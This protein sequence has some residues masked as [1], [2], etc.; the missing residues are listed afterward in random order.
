LY[1]LNQLDLALSRL[2]SEYPDLPV[3]VAGDFNQTLT[4]YIVGS[5]EGRERLRELLT[6]HDLVA[7]TEASPSALPACPSV[8]HLCAKSS[9]GDPVVWLANRTSPTPDDDLT[10]HAGYLVEVVP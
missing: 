4:G 1:V 2:R 8:D 5:L 9:E 6:R 7:F 3:L 10:H